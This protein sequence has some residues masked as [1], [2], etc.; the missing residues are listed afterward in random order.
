MGLHDRTVCQWKIEY[1]YDENDKTLERITEKNKA[2]KN[3]N[4]IDDIK[5]Q[6]DSLINELN[7][8]FAP[9][10]QKEK[11]SDSAVLIRA[12]NS[13][14]IN[15]ILAKNQF[16][17]Q[18]T[19]WK[20]PP[21][22]SLVLEHVYGMQLS[23]RRNSVMYLHLASG[24]VTNKP[25]E[26][27]SLIVDV[28]GLGDKLGAQAN[29][30][31]LLLPKLLGPHYRYLVEK[32]TQAFEPIK[33]NTCHVSQSGIGE[34]KASKTGAYTQTKVCHKHFIYFS[35]RLGIVFNPLNNK[36]DFYEGHRLKI[37]T[38]VIHP[39]RSLIATG[40]VNVNPEIHVWDPQT[41]ETLAVLCTSHKGGVLHLAFSGD[42]TKLISVGMDSTFSIQVFQWEQQRSI[43]FRN[44]GK[45]P[46]F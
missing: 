26:K 11:F 33:Y 30:L 31:E 5:I 38:M 19:I 14:K 9:A 7:Y 41:L 3:K 23:D 27:K 29:K 17:L 39:K 18:D 35:S 2:Q 6:D 40:E 24:D 10:N 13:K 4:Y 1:L 12:S 16:D 22:A 25:E 8:A 37:S 44:T 46:I 42:G 21:P 32:G 20:R 45:L 43:V 28:L 34:A 36:Q 15:R